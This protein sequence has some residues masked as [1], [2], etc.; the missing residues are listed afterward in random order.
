MTVAPF[1]SDCS[2]T[3]AFAANSTREPI[4]IPKA[5]GTPGSNDAFRVRAAAT[6]ILLQGEELVATLSVH[7]FTQKVPAVFNASIGG[8]FRHCLDHF[9]C[10]IRDLSGG[11]IDY[12]RR[13]RDA[14]MEESPEF[15]LGVARDLRQKLSELP[16]ELLQREVTARC[17]VSYEHGDSPTTQSTGSRELV[18]CIAHAIH[19]YA[20]I[21]VMARLGGVTLPCGFGIAP[22]TVN[23]LKAQE[24][25]RA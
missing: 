22:S 17:E 10:L 5:P 3:P 15:V 25:R 16:L 24:T 20:L 18:Y 12:D 14:R 9:L 6:A 4:A 13:Q 11:T 2:S 23:Y 19:H 21:S 7:D 8:H 1:E